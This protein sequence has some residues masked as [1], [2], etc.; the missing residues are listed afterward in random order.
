MQGFRLISKKNLHISVFFRNFAPNFIDGDMTAEELAKHRQE[1]RD[2]LVRYM[3]GYRIG[4][5]ATERDI[6]Y[7]LGLISDSEIIQN[8][9]NGSSPLSTI[10]PLVYYVTLAPMPRDSK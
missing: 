6:D 7:L 3:D 1:Y 10:E 9:E 2:E 5:R 8:V 4:P